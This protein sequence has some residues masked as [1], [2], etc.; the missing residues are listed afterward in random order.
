[1]G[2]KEDSSELV[3]KN[4]VSLNLKDL[5]TPDKNEVRVYATQQWSDKSQYLAVYQMGSTCET[6]H[7]QDRKKKNLKVYIY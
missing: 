4:A 2:I 6:V 3:P 1:M 7:S 5:R